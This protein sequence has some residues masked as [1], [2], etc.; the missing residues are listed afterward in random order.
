M[1]KL[2]PEEL[3]Q[4]RDR[5][6]GSALMREGGGKARI[7]VHLGTCGIASGAEEILRVFKELVAGYEGRD[8][9]L[10]TSGCA[11]LCRREPM[12]T[13]QLAGEAP[14][15]Y[16]ELTPAKVKKV[17]QSHVLGGAAVDEFALVRGSEQLS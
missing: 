3:V 17:F 13:V 11:G 16:V 1:K 6:Q 15:K 5:M 12:A 9:Q 4:I 14:I 8:V 10:T 2:T 7:T